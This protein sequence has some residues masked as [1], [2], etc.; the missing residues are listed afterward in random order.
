MP[1]LFRLL[2]VTLILAIFGTIPH[3]GQAEI[4]PLGKAT[5]LPIG[6]GDLN[7]TVE[8]TRKG[9]NSFVFKTKIYFYG[10]SLFSKTNH[11]E[12]E[13]SGAYANP[14]RWVI[15]AEVYSQP[16]DSYNDLPIIKE[17]IQ[18]IVAE[19]ATLF[20][21]DFLKLELQAVF[22]S[23]KTLLGKSYSSYQKEKSAA[24]AA[25]MLKD[26]LKLKTT[27]TP[28]KDGVPIVVS[29]LLERG[30]GFVTPNIWAPYTPSRLLAHEFGHILGTLTEGY[31][32]QDYPGNGLMNCEYEFIALEQML[33][34]IPIQYL[35]AD[36][37]EA[38]RAM[39]RR[40]K[41]AVDS[42][43]LD[44]EFS[45]FNDLFDPIYQHYE[46]TECAPEECMQRAKEKVA[47][48]NHP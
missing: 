3:Q 19:I 8:A 46:K 30:P 4:L 23:D 6:F 28:L 39:V 27:K 21:S 48:L 36:F 12:I 1:Q 18:E 37:N 15:P 2:I 42:T 43:Q 35:R 45:P 5:R 25:H 24:L 22:P 14:N 16:A 17:R 47:K 41:I 26:V 38:V 34:Q 11:Q 32:Y 13:A 7:G 10:A 40:A 9:K 44:R 20:E 29:P 31:D 33:P